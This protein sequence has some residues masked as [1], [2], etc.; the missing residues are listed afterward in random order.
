[1]QV[2]VCGHH[3][4]IPSRQQVL[5]YAAGHLQRRAG[6]AG[7]CL[8]PCFSGQNCLHIAPR[9]AAQA[10]MHKQEEAQPTGQ[11][12]AASANSVPVAR[13][14]LGGVAVCHEVAH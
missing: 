14:M 7:E 10:C 4:N 3:H 12:P 13:P 1:M 5:L 8:Q 11:V 2:P 9:L 6:D